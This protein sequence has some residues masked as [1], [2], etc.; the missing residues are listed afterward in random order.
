MPTEQ[1][2]MSPTDRLNCM[3][4]LC[5]AV[6]ETGKNI[7]RMEPGEISDTVQQSGHQFSTL[8][9][10]GKILLRQAVQKH[11]GDVCAGFIEESDIKLGDSDNSQ[12]Y[13][14]AIGDAV[15]G[16][17]NAKRGLSSVLAQHTK[18]PIF[19][20]TS[21]MLLE[22]KK[23]SSIIAT[24]FF[25]WLSGNT[26]SS[27]RTE[28]GYFQAFINGNIVY[29]RDAAAK[30]RDSQQYAIVP[31]YSHSNILERAQTEESLL[32]AG[33]RSDGGTRSSA[34]DMLQVFCGQVDAYVDLRRI[35][36][37][38]SEN[39][40]EVLR[41][42]DVGALL[43]FLDALGFSLTDEHAVSWQEKCFGDSLTLVVARDQELWKKI[44]EA[45]SHLGFMQA[46][47]AKDSSIISMSR[48]G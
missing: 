21:V 48:S 32:A 24:A 46:D 26:F 18:R 38:R 45:I 35:F 33:I 2:M 19:A 22:E 40:D 41:A 4:A 14:V 37:Q 9:D 31:G 6:T 30:P 3:A 11:L 20:G 44:N 43:P 5:E 16:S 15:E 25:D 42:W 10:A 29:P 39:R 17:T 1:K 8:D 27:V 34:Q 23:M 47:S 36:S 28:P 12:G 7:L 13:P